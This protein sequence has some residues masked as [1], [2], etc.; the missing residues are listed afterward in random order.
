ML[1]GT[2]KRPF[3]AGMP[4]VAATFCSRYVHVVHVVRFAKLEEAGPKFKMCAMCKRDAQFQCRHAG[5][6]LC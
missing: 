5:S 1:V 6:F 3:N 2:K 4:F